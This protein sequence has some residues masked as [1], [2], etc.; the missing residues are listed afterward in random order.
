MTASRPVNAWKTN[1]GDPEIKALG[2]V[3]H[4]L[5]NEYARAIGGGHGTVHQQQE[6]EKH[7]TSQ[8]SPEQF[9]AVVA[10]MKREIALA[11]H[12]MPEARQQ[13]HGLFAHDPVRGILAA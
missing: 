9:A 10:I 13:I 7:L 3:I 6:A 5:S 11:E 8:D 12:A 2:Q 4:T 1:T